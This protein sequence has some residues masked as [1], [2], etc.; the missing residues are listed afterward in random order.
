MR[1]HRL[2]L[3]AAASLAAGA[4][5]TTTPIL[6]GIGGG[7]TTGGSLTVTP[8]SVQLHVGGTV[9]LT[10]NA[11]VDQESQLEWSSNEPQFAA[12]S[13]SGLVTGIA[14]GSAT[15]STVVSSDTTIT[16]SSTIT[17]VP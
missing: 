7:T 8:A 3:V 11:T 16:G 13:P 15:I 12:V 4:C 5:D 2:I 1:L 6:A 17:V 14:T 10:T 9:Q